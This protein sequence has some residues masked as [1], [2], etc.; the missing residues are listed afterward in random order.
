MWQEHRDTRADI[1]AQ[2]KELE[3]APELAMISLLCLL[4]APQVLIQLL[5]REPGRPINALQHRATLVATPVGSRYTHEFEG[6]NLARILHMRPTTQVQEVALL[7]DA[8]FLIG[9]IL[10]D[11]DLVD[12]TLIA[13]VLQCL[14]AGPAVAQEWILFLNNAFHTPLNLRQIIGCE[15]TGQIEIIVETIFDS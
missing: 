12:L 2:D 10:N 11:L 1:V 14:L 7:I 5:L 4:Q 6:T 3:L 15:R 9:Q 13:E 8:D